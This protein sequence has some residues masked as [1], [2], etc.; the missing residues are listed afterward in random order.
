M[1][2]TAVSVEERERGG[3]PSD[4]LSALLGL[5][6]KTG[7]NAGSPFF[8]P[9]LL[10][11][12]LRRNRRRDLFLEAWPI[13]YIHKHRRRLRATVEFENTFFKGKLLHCS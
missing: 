11:K 7:E 9:S 3:D 1:G 8:S 5:W 12:T 4:S 13:P 2:E 6:R 10:Q